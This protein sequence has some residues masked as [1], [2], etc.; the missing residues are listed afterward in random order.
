MAIA[1]SPYMKRFSSGCLKRFFLSQSSTSSSDI[2]SPKRMETDYHRL[3]NQLPNYLDKYW[4]IAFG[5]KLMQAA[6]WRPIFAH[7]ASPPSSRT[8][9]LDYLS[10]YLYS[11]V[12]LRRSRF[13]RCRARLKM[14]KW[15]WKLR[16][17]DGDGITHR[18]TR[19]K[20]RSLLKAYPTSFDWLLRSRSWSQRRPAM[21]TS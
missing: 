4:G 15:K 8:W 3:R 1:I 19:S 14:F 10:R 17:I 12:S 2:M 5:S 13:L 9:C 11:L 20:I 21:S 6:W 16:P 7:T 18:S